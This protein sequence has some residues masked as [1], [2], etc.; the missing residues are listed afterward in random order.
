MLVMKCITIL[1]PQQKMPDIICF[2]EN[3]SRRYQAGHRLK[4]IIVTA[5]L[6]SMDVASSPILFP[7]S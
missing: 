4:A 1:V 2:V 7:L 3:L 5:Y 6:K